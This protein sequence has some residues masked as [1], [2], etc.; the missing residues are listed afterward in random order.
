MH[1]L[2]F[3]WLF[4]VGLA[5]FGSFLACFWLKTKQTAGDFDRVQELRDA[6][7]S[8]EELRR[9]GLSLEELRPAFQIISNGLK[10]M[11]NVENMAK[12]GSKGRSTPENQR[13]NR[14]NHENPSVLS[15][16]QRF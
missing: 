8:F 7:L 13:K 1:F 16:F 6:G 2:V 10:P 4:Q 15:G 12:T 5:P 3:S 11:N 14:E 9:A